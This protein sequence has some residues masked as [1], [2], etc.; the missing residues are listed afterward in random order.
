MWGHILTY[1]TLQSYPEVSR[2]GDS[3]GKELRQGLLG[4]ITIWKRLIYLPVSLEVL[5]ETAHISGPLGLSPYTFLVSLLT[6]RPLAF[7]LFS[8]QDPSDLRV[9]HVLQTLS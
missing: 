6:L 1:V 5:M 7:Q 2:Q 9:H 3:T 4:H 8:V